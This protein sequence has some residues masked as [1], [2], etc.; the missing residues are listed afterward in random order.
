M[1]PISIDFNKFEVIDL[2]HDLF[3]RMPGWPGHSEFTLQDL[4][5]LNIDGYSVKKLSINTHHGTH[6]DVEA[7]MVENGRTLENYSLDSFMGNAVVIDVSDTQAS[8]PISLQSVKDHDKLIQ[9]NSIVLLHTGWDKFR[10]NTAKYL[11]EWPYVDTDLA[12]YLVQKH[13]KMVGTD[14]LSI[15]GWGGTTPTH[16]KVTDSA[17]EVHQ[18][19]L[20]NGLTIIE[21]MANLDKLLEDKQVVETFFIALPLNLSSVDGS[22]VRAVAFKEGEE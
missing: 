13:I 2:S 7:H 18:I 17:V 22:P 16:K 12:K 10:A 11:Y 15:G 21:E 6:M 4:K 8:S 20:K 5:I 1:F 19:L 9:S 14:G 3:H